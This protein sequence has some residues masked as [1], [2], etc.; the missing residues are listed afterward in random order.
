MRAA[1]TTH[2]HSLK[3]VCCTES[4]QKFRPWVEMQEENERMDITRRNDVPF[5]GVI[6][7]AKTKRAV[8]SREE[9]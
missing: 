8:A 2:I 7:F 6:P 9:P 4:V 3:C 1:H 5:R